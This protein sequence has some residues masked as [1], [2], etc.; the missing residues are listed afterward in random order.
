MAW[1]KF[2]SCCYKLFYDPD[3]AAV[4]Q[5]LEKGKFLAIFRKYDVDFDGFLD[6]KEFGELCKNEL[7]E[8]PSDEVAATAKKIDIDVDGYVSE[9]EFLIW[10][11]VAGTVQEVNRRRSSKGSE[12]EK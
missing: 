7:P 9:R 4:A 12:E 10:G 1:P 5:R 2:V 11:L 3:K 8:M 6:K